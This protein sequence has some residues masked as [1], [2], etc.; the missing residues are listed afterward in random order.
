M[1][2]L[3]SS[4][5]KS[6]AE[7]RNTLSTFE[8]EFS[9]SFGTIDHAR[10]DFSSLCHQ[11]FFFFSSRRRHTRSLCDWSSDVCSS[12]LPPPDWCLHA[13][14]QEDLRLD[15]R[16]QRGVAPHA[17][18]AE[19]PAPQPLS[20][21]SR[22][23][24]SGPDHA[25]RKRGLEEKVTHPFT[26]KP[27]PSSDDIIIS[28]SGSSTVLR[29]GAG[30]ARLMRSD[31]F[32]LIRE[33]AEKHGGLA[34]INLPETSPDGSFTPIGT[35]RPVEVDGHAALTVTRISP[36]CGYLVPHDAEHVAAVLLAYARNP[37][38]PQALLAKALADAIY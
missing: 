8:D 31:L 18:L 16:G 3:G 7:Y 17:A 36:S 10:L 22:P 38:D 1:S 6:R 32:M 24:A 15:G 9:M 25:P 29:V 20:V 35:V 37:V 11:A 23:L 26:L 14:R 2:S 13:P 12:D 21:P 4:A 28:E 33:L 27:G 34:V 30:H 5:V 19:R